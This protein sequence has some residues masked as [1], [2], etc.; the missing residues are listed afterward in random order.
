MDA[1]VERKEALAE[2]ARDARVPK[3]KV[4]DA[5]LAEKDQPSGR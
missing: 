2:V 4:F 5:L 1:G 3:R